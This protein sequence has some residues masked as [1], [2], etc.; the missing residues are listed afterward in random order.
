MGV[1]ET[2][3]LQV[4]VAVRPFIKLAAKYFGPYP[5]EAKIGAVTYRLLMPANVL[6]HPI[7]HVS[8]H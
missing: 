1:S 6:I 2:S 3:A 7:F 5:V 4:S 8:Q